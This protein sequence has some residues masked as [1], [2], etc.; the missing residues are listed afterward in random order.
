MFV[1]GKHSI[2][3]AITAVLL[4]PSLPSNSFMS[5]PSSYAFL[6]VRNRYGYSGYCPDRQRGC[7]NVYPGVKSN[8]VNEISS[9]ST[10]FFILL[11]TSLPSHTPSFLTLSQ[12]YTFSFRIPIRLSSSAT[13]SQYHLTHRNF[14]KSSLYHAIRIPRRQVTAG[15]HLPTLPIP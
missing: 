12:P 14:F 2:R 1:E 9:S 3:V 13:G 8:E 6:R 4:N 15:L 5:A 11:N 7:G 10:R